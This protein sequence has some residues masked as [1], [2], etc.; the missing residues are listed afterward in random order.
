VDAGGDAHKRVVLE[1]ALPDYLRVMYPAWRIW[2]AAGYW[3]ACRR[4]NFRQV[5]APGA[6]VYALHADSPAGLWGRLVSESDKEHTLPIVRD[7]GDM[8]YGG[9]VPFRLSPRVHGNG[10]RDGA[11]AETHLRLL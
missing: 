1:A 9:E 5:F 7:A 2:E 10:R 3:H 8:H 11:C 4:G 6:Q